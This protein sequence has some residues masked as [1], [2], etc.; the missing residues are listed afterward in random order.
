MLERVASQIRTALRSGH[1]SLFGHPVHDA[2]SFFDALD[3]DSSGAI[4]PLEVAAGL[5]RLDVAI[6]QEDVLNFVNSF[7]LDANG[8]IARAELL[9]VLKPVQEVGETMP[10]SQAGP[11]QTSRQRAGPA[12][13]PG[14]NGESSGTEHVATQTDPEEQVSSSSI[15]GRRPVIRR[16]GQATD[17]EAERRLSEDD[18]RY[19]AEVAALDAKL[20][21]NVRAAAQRRCSLKAKASQRAAKEMSP[22]E[23][24][25]D[26]ELQRRVQE[27]ER[28]IQ[29]T[30]DE[31]LHTRGDEY[32]RRH[33]TQESLRLQRLEEEERRRRAEEDDDTVRRAEDRQRLARHRTVE[34]LEMKRRADE[35]E[36]RRRLRHDEEQRLMHEKAREKR[37]WDERR[38][39]R[40]MEQ[41][42]AQIRFALRGNRMLFGQQ[43]RDARS[44]FDTLD[45]D[46]DGA[47]DPVEVAAGLKRLDVAVSED[48]LCAFIS[49]L[50]LN[51]NSLVEREEL[52][53]GLSSPRLRQQ[54]ADSGTESMSSRSGNSPAPRK[55]SGSQRRPWGQHAMVP[56]ANTAGT[57]SAPAGNAVDARQRIPSDQTLISLPSSR[58][59]SI[60]RPTRST[61]LRQGIL[62]EPPP[63]A[64][65]ATLAAATGAVSGSGC[66]GAT[67]ARTARAVGNS[68]GAMSIPAA[69]MDG[70]EGAFYEGRVDDELDIARP[71][72]QHLQGAG[73]AH[74]SR[75]NANN[76][77]NPGQRCADSPASTV[78]AGSTPPA[79][80]RLPNSPQ[81]P[82]QQ[83]WRQQQQ[84]QHKR[85]SETF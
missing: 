6:S 84:Q 47:L 3:R 4:D 24:R 31:Y 42:A 30:T 17:D 60:N 80:T 62:P 54:R 11:A 59:G 56:L 38:S 32:S 5:K 39:R 51:G 40:A 2:E 76:S 75:G 41:V 15:R 70:S 13:S 16:V 44:F 33:K 46:K 53:H 1:R 49:T 57:S 26:E 25:I 9:H 67:A 28:R 66:S 69:I 55:R 82:K 58:S 71:A 61:L 22:E 78:G 14:R 48:E 19:A 7:D 21:Q 29:E 77:P 34:E 83:R 85:R 10:T 36:H 72:L 65:A 73:S 37:L 20:R 27:A 68:S 35:Q 50:D 63:H 12:A 8:Q 74:S 81:T 23:R 52:V 79:P 64:S 45:Q 43:I 18:R